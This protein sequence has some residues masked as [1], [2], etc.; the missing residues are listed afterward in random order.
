MIAYIQYP[1]WIRPEIIPG[2]PIRW[3]GLMY[4]VAFVIAYFLLAKQ[5]AERNIPQ[6]KEEAVNL[7]T[8]GIVGLL[9]GARIFA[10]L[11]YDDTV[12]YLTHP[13][14][15]F[16]PFDSHMHFTGLM[17]MSFHGG[18]IGCSLGTYFYSA[19]HK[20]SCWA[21][22]DMLVTA[23]PFGYFF[24]RLGNFINAE[25]YGRVTTAPIGMMFPG[26]SQP[27]HPSQLYEAFFEGIFLGILMWF[28]FRKMKLNVGV[29]TGLF[30]FCYGIIRFVIE[31]FRE[32][33]ANLGFVFLNF[34][35]GQVLCLLMMIFGTAIILI[36]GR[37]TT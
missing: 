11:V 27:R 31:Y 19:K 33:D 23:I 22:T 10:T 30:L 13:W 12:L 36:K 7:A 5:M 24:G 28:V 37:K 35:M 26:H 6:P 2:L 3:Y 32:P 21:N 16:W 29:R 25:L 4:L 34:T 20:Q 9:L 15:I 14:L 8:W 17:G 1:E 18:V